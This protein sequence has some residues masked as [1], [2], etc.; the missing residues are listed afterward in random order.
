MSSSHWYH[1]VANL[2]YTE[3]RHL[4]QYLT[5]DLAQ[6]HDPTTTDSWPNT[7]KPDR[8]ERDAAVSISSVPTL[9]QSGRS[10]PQSIQI[11]SGDPTAPELGTLYEPNPQHFTSH[12]ALLHAPNSD[13]MWQNVPIGSG[14]QLLDSSFLQGH[15][16]NSS[17][18]AG[19]LVA[20]RSGSSERLFHCTF[21]TEDGKIKTC[22]TKQDW[23]RHEQDFHDTGNEWH[24]RHA[25]C[26]EVFTRHQDFRKHCDKSHQRQGQF[27]NTKVEVIQQQRVYACGV[28]SC[29]AFLHS[30]KERCDHVARCTQDHVSEW[31]YNR[32]IRN[33][34]RHPLVSPT[35]KLV[36][37]RWCPLLGVDVSDLNWDPR[38]T[39]NIREQ[40]ECH[41]FGTGLE[42]LLE[43]LVRVGH[44]LHNVSSQFPIQMV[45]SH[46]PQVPL[47]GSIPMMNDQLPHLSYGESQSSVFIFG[48]RQRRAIDDPTQ[49][50]K[51]TMD[52][53]GHRNSIVMADAPPFNGPEAQDS[54][55]SCT[56][57]S[58]D[59]KLM[60]WQDFLYSPTYS[61]NTTPR[62]IESSND[63]QPS[64]RSRGS[65]GLM[66]KS[67]E[68]FANKRSQHSQPIVLDHPDVPANIRLPSSSTD[69]ARNERG[70]PLE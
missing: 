37:A 31:N 57:G 52:P 19:D 53:T 5:E 6:H 8:I 63:G 58:R 46:P 3:R 69:K 70:E 68:F 17:V 2:S 12:T 23:K 49:A 60:S 7:N 54:G 35:W 42:T 40:L 21:C 45:P 51:V 50:N 56:I 64:L 24:C 22:K 48:E 34:L 39:H 28:E 11:P 13:S 1:L 36:H 25:G 55:T 43:G 27:R 14:Q 16:E 38:T 66:R 33:L 18:A 32:I 30:W 15:D 44:P 29:R 65:R 26:S 62:L 67:K 61:T 9:Y 47:Q 10:T 20:R 4:H 59:Q 41:S